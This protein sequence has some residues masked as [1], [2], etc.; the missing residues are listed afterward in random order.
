MLVGIEKLLSCTENLGQAHKTTIFNQ[1]CAPGWLTY[2]WQH[3]S[4]TTC[5]EQ[6][7]IWHTS[8]TWTNRA[9]YFS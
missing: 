2:Y 7:K 5:T 3:N 8:S 9:L 6:V 4:Q 1:E